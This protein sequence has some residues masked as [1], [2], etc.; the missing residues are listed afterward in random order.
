MD[1]IH[2]AAQRFVPVFFSLPATILLAYSYEHREVSRKTRCP[3]DLRVLNTVLFLSGR[4]TS[5]LR[6]GR[7]S[8]FQF[9]SLPVRTQRKLGIYNFVSPHRIF[10][11]LSSPASL[12]GPKKTE[13]PVFC[14]KL[15]PPT[16]CRSHSALYG[17]QQQRKKKIATCITTTAAGVET[18][19]FF[20]STSA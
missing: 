9:V 18:L 15:L 11:C 2:R 7:H 20:F 4:R 10:S 8:L 3:P 16:C 19:Y 1:K 6:L 13:D 5:L 14:A 17:L 12:H